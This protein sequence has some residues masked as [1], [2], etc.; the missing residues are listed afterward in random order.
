MNLPKDTATSPSASTPD[1]AYWVSI[2]E[3][4]SRPVLENLA[5]RTLKKNMP[6]EQQPGS[7]REPVSPLEAFGRLLYG[8]A[9]WLAA[10][11]LGESER[12]SQTH[13]QNLAR[14]A[15][16]AATDPHSPDFMDFS[17][18]GQPLV[19][20]AFLAQGIL[21]APHILWDPLEPRVK[22]QIIQALQATRSFKP[23][24]C[25]WVL[26]AA[27]VESALLTFGQPTSEDRLEGYVRDML[28]WYCGDGIYGDGEF[29]HFDYYNSFVIHSMLVDVL[30]TLSRHDARFGPAR[31]TAWERMTRYAEIQ[32][33]LIAPD[34]SFP[35]VG[36]S[37][38]YRAGAF[39][40]LAHAA[41][42]HRLPTTITPTQVRSAL[43]AILH[44]TLDV[45]GTFDAEGWLR[46]GL[47]G[48][49]LAQGETYISTGSLYLC[50][51]AHLPL[52]LPPADDFWS[53]P[54]EPWTAQKIWSGV[55][56]PADHAIQDVRTVDV[57]T[58]IRS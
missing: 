26:F 41:W 18:P 58:L 2:T 20:T 3:K 36:R 44:R 54:A 13:F 43:T 22:H 16:D 32:E 47:C 53:S 11:G 1:R 49:Q 38:A 9:P 7:K 4:I 23:H 14:T 15:L 35:P 29:F 51:A 24:P 57:P 21:R 52:G 34:G 17:T 45:P 40:T 33:R 50:T 8:I 10:T 56:L 46:I 31:E 28:G 6:V 48:P 19:D 30:T 37:L 25:N 12:A 42:E 55:N 5:R 27:T 39:Q